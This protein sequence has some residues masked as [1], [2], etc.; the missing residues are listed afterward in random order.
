LNAFIQTIFVFVCLL[1]FLVATAGI[2]VHW[3]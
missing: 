1:G 2:E 3:V